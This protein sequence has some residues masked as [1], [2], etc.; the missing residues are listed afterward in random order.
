MKKIIK[1][2][3][4]V[5]LIVVITILSILWTIAFISIQWY[6]RDARNSKR[7]SDVRNIESLMWIYMIKNDNYPIPDDYIEIKKWPIIFT[8]QWVLKQKTLWNLWYQWDLLDPITN[9]PYTYSLNKSKNK[10]D[11]L[12]YLENG[13]SNNLFNQTYANVY[14]E[15]IIKTRGSSIWILTD[16]ESKPVNLSGSNIDL[17]TN[18]NI[19][20]LYYNSKSLS[21]GWSDM[22]SYYSYLSNRFESDDNLVWYWNMEDIIIQNWKLYIE[23]KSYNN[24]HLSIEW[25][26][27]IL[28]IWEKIN[29]SYINLSDSWSYLKTELTNTWSVSWSL[30][31]WYT[32]IISHK[33][34]VDNKWKWLFFLNEA[35][36]LSITSTTWRVYWSA[37]NLWTADLTISDKDNQLWKWNIS[38]YT[39]DDSSKISRIYSNWILWDEELWQNVTNFNPNSNTIYIWRRWFN[40][41]NFVWNIDEVYLFKKALTSSWIELFSDKLRK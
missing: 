4:L 39:Y 17:S 13:S 3:T 20:N 36:N 25:D 14:E 33:S 2:F 40:D 5:E 30:N 11:I 22:I 31:N 24:N 7:L 27:K 10:F 19:F 41:T 16:N 1:W 9:I 37:Y 23:D 8:Y 28:S 29:W 18:S 35:Y 26:S 38:A 21:G 12:Y 15:W 32:I 6:S 34:D